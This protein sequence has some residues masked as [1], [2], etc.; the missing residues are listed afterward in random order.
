MYF[1]HLV[2]LSTGAKIGVGFGTGAGV[3][4]VGLIAFAALKATGR[5]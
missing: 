1:V 2:R 4:L 3:V 5:V